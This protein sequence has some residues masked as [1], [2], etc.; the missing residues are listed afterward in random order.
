MLLG[1]IPL[2]FWF[3]SNA[4]RHIVLVPGAVAQWSERSL[5]KGA[6]RRWFESNLHPVRLCYV[7]GS[8]EAS[9]AGWLVPFCMGT[10]G[11]VKACG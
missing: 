2:G 9:Q 8:R 4:V 6:A 10:G 3:D 7:A 11:A 1:W 5:A